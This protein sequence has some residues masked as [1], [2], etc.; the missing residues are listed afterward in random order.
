[1]YLVLVKN[2]SE[3][4]DVVSYVNVLES[5]HAILDEAWESGLP[6]TGMAVNHLPPSTTVKGATWD[7]TSFSGGTPAEG[8]PSDDD[9]ETWGNITRYAF[10]ADSKVVLL[11]VVNNDGPKSEMFSAAFEGDVAIAK[12]PEGSSFE[13]GNTVSWVGNEIT[14]L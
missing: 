11:M 3:N 10:L 12:S 6:I 7:G 9:S 5:A 13:I 4:W 14:L 8:L 2:D 1:V